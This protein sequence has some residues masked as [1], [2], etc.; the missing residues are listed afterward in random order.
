MSEPEVSM[1]IPAIDLNR[2]TV[3]CSVME[4]GSMTGA[5]KRSETHS[6]GE[7]PVSAGF[8]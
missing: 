3:F 1:A 2:L 5:A 8:G 6:P 4:A 7:C